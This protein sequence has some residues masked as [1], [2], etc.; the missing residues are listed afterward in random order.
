M[1]PFLVQPVPSFERYRLDYIASHLSK[2]LPVATQRTIKPS[3]H[4]AV[5]KE[6]F[7]ILEVIAEDH[8]SS[9]YEA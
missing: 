5:P 7:T 2:L 4:A 6:H 3:D 9:C 1:G 8:H